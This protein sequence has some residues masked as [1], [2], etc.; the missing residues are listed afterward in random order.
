[1]YLTIHIV[2]VLMEQPYYSHL[3]AFKLAISDLR[4]ILQGQAS[5]KY[6]E[7]KDRMHACEIPG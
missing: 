7:R 4:K 5:L 2:I 6:E 3:K 1:M